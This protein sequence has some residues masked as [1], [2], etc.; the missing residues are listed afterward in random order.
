M[1]EEND[2]IS[3]WVP[4]Q[5]N[6]DPGVVRR[7]K[8]QTNRAGKRLSGIEVEEKSLNDKND[9]RNY[10]KSCDLSLY[11]VRYCLLFLKFLKL[12]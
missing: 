4:R 8:T 9:Q 6:L 11:Q 2:T 3:E 5:P 1:Q 10:R 12:V 7:R